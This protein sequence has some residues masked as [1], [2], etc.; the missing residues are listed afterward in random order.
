MRRKPVRL[1]RY[2][3]KHHAARTLSVLRRAWP[4]TDFA[5]VPESLGFGWNILAT[6]PQGSGLVARAPLSMIAHRGAMARQNKES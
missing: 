3:A 5:L 2:S 4:E 1:F 6:T